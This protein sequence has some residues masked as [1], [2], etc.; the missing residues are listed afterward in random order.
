MTKK[1]Q[2]PETDILIES[3]GKVESFFDKYGSKLMWALVAITIIAVGIFIWRNYAESSQ[4]ERAAEANKERR[5]LEMKASA[6][7]FSIDYAET[8]A[9]YMAIANKYS[10]TA[11]G[12]L[13]YYDAAANYLR[14]GDLAN[15]KAALAKFQNVEG[16]FGALINAQALVLAGD[17]AVEEGDFQTAAAKFEK[18]LAACK[19]ANIYGEAALKLGLTY[20]AMGNDAKAQQ[21]YKAAAEKHASLV[22][23]FAKYIKE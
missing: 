15:A 5:E 19:N 20:E 12:N 16:D 4:Q 10:D 14:A 17:I 9:A 13:C 6:E 3:K 8:A 2:N 23:K 22:A 21:V 11:E 7:D 18:A 1:V